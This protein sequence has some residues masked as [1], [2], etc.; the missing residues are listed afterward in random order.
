MLSAIRS[1][2]KARWR[3]S[4]RRSSVG[5]KTRFSKKRSSCFR[6]SRHQG[7]S[8]ASILA[9][10]GADMQQFPTAAKLGSWAGLWPANH[11]SAKC[12]HEP[13]KRLAEAHAHTER[14]GGH[15]AKGSKTAGTLPCPPRSLRRQA[16]HRQQGSRKNETFLLT[17]DS[18][19]LY[20][21][22][23]ISK[24]VIGCFSGFSG[25]H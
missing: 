14:L 16:C 25:D 9:E 1:S 5:L 8:A 19:L 11:E 4:T 13:R 20:T 6:A 23:R 10:V 15:R 12:S 22:M 24:R 21:L 17:V 7:E 3:R 18:S 2:W